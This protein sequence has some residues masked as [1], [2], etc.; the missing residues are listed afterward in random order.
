M[1][2]TVRRLKF[3]HHLGDLVYSDCFHLPFTFTCT[4]WLGLKNKAKKKT[5]PERD[6]AL[7]KI[8]LPLHLEKRHTVNVM[9]RYPLQGFICDKVRLRV[10]KLKGVCV[11][12]LVLNKPLK[13]VFRFSVCF[14]VLRVCV[15]HGSVSDMPKTAIQLQTAVRVTLW[16]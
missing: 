11:R 7:S 2:K 1:S 5:G 9:P 15:D 14:R 10:S 6:C 4:C 8:A 3:V 12:V 13:L 16:F